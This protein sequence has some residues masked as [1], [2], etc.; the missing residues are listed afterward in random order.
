MNLQPDTPGRMYERY[1]R[2]RV[3]QH[4]GEQHRRIADVVRACQIVDGFFVRAAEDSPVTVSFTDLVVR[5][6]TAN[7]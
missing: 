3:F 6:V 4:V 2:L 1:E 7:Q 5:A